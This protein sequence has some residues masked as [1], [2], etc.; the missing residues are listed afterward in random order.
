MI[1]RHGHVL[2]SA[3]SVGHRGVP[4]IPGISEQAEIGQFESL[5]HFAL[6]PKIRFI[7]FPGVCC[8]DEHQNHQYNVRANIQKIDI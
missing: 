8:M 5:Y 3:V 1:K 6:F 7:G 2:K 4:G